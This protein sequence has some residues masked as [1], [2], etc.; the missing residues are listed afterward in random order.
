MKKKLRNIVMTVLDLQR[1]T[2]NNKMTAFFK[3]PL[4]VPQDVSVECNAYLFHQCQTWGILLLQE[5]TTIQYPVHF[6]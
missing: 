3:G 6:K 1:H 5:L 4:Q 2:T